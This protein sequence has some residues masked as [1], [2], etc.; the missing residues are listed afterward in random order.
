MKN[1]LNLFLALSM[2]VLSAS[3]CDKEDRNLYKDSNGNVTELIG[4]W[5]LVEVQYNTAGV[6][7]SRTLEPESLMEFQEKGVGRSLRLCA[8]GRLDEISTFHYEKYRGSVTIFTEEE[9]RNNQQRSE[10]DPDYSRGTTYYFKV[11]DYDTI[12]SRE[13]VTDGTYL[14]NIFRRF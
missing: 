14:V 1:V 9:W 12:S 13:R 8:D 6:T 2:V 10:E 5:G 4:R 7:E 3:T 11:I